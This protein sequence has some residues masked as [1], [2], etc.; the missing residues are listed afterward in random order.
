M[1][2]LTMIVFASLGLTA[3]LQ[4]QPVL[5]PAVPVS[6]VPSIPAMPALPAPVALTA[7]TMPAD[8]PEWFDQDRDAER[9]ERERR[10]AERNRES[11]A[12]D[13]GLQALDQSRWDRAI[14]DFDRVVQLKGSKADAALYWKAYAQNKLGQRADALGTIAQLARDYPDSRYQQQAKALEV[15][16]RRD[17]G[18]PVRP[19]NENDEDLKLMALQALQNSEPEQAI[20]MLM[21]ILQGTSSPRLKE[22]ALFVLAQSGS[23]AARQ[24]L[25]NIAKGGSTPELQNKAI[26]YLGTFGSAESRAALADIYQGTSDVD[27]KRRILRA[28]MIAGE[29]ARLLTAA[30]HEQ[31]PDLRQE[32]VRQ[33]GVMGAHDELWT[34]YQKETAIDVKKQIL[35]AMF[36]GGNAARLID[37]AKTEPNPELRRLAVRNLGLMGGKET[38][39]ALVGIYG[40]NSDPQ[41]RKAVV[42]ALFIQ[43]NAASLVA[44]AR[45]EQDIEMKKAIVSKLSLM[46][47]KAATDYLLEILNK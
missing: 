44:L 7:W 45:K 10:E 6:A 36:V 2:T 21:K 42:Q 19:E 30:Q 33:L 25:V 13:R 24:A 32:A 43:G 26:Q 5:P 28:F 8:D 18:Q 15:E 20:Q 47:D 1:K 4:A 37:L 12:Y 39:D 41:I 23:A 38:G 16:V 9:Q 31:N 3:P 46:H 17:T 35:Q 22:R 27:V 11:S 34:M 40:S 29:K 14:A